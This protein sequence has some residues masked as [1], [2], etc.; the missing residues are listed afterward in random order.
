M[1]CDDIPMATDGSES[2]RQYQCEV[3]L[4][5]EAM[6]SHRNV[7]YLSPGKPAQGWNSRNDPGK[8]KK[9]T[10]T[11]RSMLIRRGTKWLHVEY[12]A[13][14]QDPRFSDTV[15]PFEA[16]V[17][18][19]GD[20]QIFQAYSFILLACLLFYS[21]S[22]VFSFRHQLSM[23]FS[24]LRQALADRAQSRAKMREAAA[25]DA[26]VVAKLSAVDVVAKQN[27]V[28]LRQADRYLRSYEVN[29]R[30]SVA[31]ISELLVENAVE[32]LS[33]VVTI[34]I[35]SIM[36]SS[37]NDSSLVEYVGG[38][39]FIQ[40]LGAFNIVLMTITF[41]IK[42]IWFHPFRQ[43]VLTV[44][45]AKSDL[46]N[47]M[48]TM[49]LFMITFAI[50]G[51]IIFGVYDD[52]FDASG[53]GYDLL[54]VT[55]SVFTHLIDPW[56]KADVLTNRF[57]ST[58]YY[59][60]S[61]TFF[62]LI[63]SQF[64]IAVLCDSFTSVREELSAAA[65]HITLKRGW[66]MGN[67][68]W[69]SW[70]TPFQHVQASILPNWAPHGIPLSDLV[71]LLDDADEMTFNQLELTIRT[72]LMNQG[73]TYNLH[74]RQ[75]LRRP[76]S[77]D[78]AG[79][80]K[81]RAECAVQSTQ[82]SQWLF[83]HFAAVPVA[84]RKDPPAFFKFFH[85]NRVL[86]EMD[87]F[88]LANGFFRDHPAVTLAQS[89]EKEHFRKAFAEY[90]AALQSKP[91]NTVSTFSDEDCGGSELVKVF[92]SDGE[93]TITFKDQT[94]SARLVLG[95]DQSVASAIITKL[96]LHLR[97]QQVDPT[98]D[99]NVVLT[100]D[101]TIVTITNPKYL[102]PNIHVLSTL[103]RKDEARGPESVMFR[104]TIME[105]SHEEQ[106]DGHMEPLNKHCHFTR[107][108]GGGA[109][110][111]AS[112]DAV[113]DEFSEAY[114]IKWCDETGKH[115]TLSEHWERNPA[116]AEV[117]CNY[118]DCQGA[119]SLEEKV[120]AALV[121]MDRTVGCTA[122]ERANAPSFR[123]E[124]LEA[125]KDDEGCPARQEVGRT[126]NASE[127]VVRCF[128]FTKNERHDELEP[129][130]Q[131]CFQNPSTT[132]RSFSEQQLQVFRKQFKKFDK[133]KGADG[134]LNFV[135]LTAVLGSLGMELINEDT[136]K[137]VMK[138]VDQ[139]HSK[140]LEFSEFI[141][142]M[143]QLAI[144]CHFETGESMDLFSYDGFGY[145]S[146][147]MVREWLDAAAELTGEEEEA[148]RYLASSSL[149]SGSGT[150]ASGHA[151]AGS[152]DDLKQVKNSVRR[153]EEQVE[154]LTNKFDRLLQE[155][156]QPR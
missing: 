125:V 104:K 3:L 131:L 39:S 27:H 75:A 54:Y 137:Q 50:V 22:L 74:G 106:F 11:M 28:L 146:F 99:G 55:V 98:L 7:V 46:L 130:Y 6:G 29:V 120:T 14:I 60:A 144:L 122:M 65:S 31:K 90:M 13:K 49:I 87:R 8:G 135:E 132:G 107:V 72:F 23:S 114:E 77:D 4:D 1:T 103:G 26:A 5:R 149:A 36:I 45:H 152:G 118:F 153:V 42:M 129:E 76:V 44:S 156:Q 53:S 91:V 62:L 124:F 57:A 35:T 48:V 88:K 47:F 59:V 123:I 78:A 79:V 66:Q 2:G 16:F 134:E 102:E 70:M 96:P 63:F 41:C 147:G 86:A 9:I 117:L 38:I 148:K 43:L 24:Y 81:F 12:A 73:R 69:A 17:G 142:L 126:L 18:M 138:E 21:W 133:Q 33:W 71:D 105:G 84:L 109:S 67:A 145:M 37:S 97:V 30:K 155:L 101:N 89:K 40:Q 150:G 85:T 56:E 94:Q 116:T 95:N 51:V 64:L 115:T 113:T 20:S 110:V 127:A 80:V 121:E 34:V 100:D 32:L 82:I 15:T 19:E 25:L 58:L 136:L 141:K 139:D 112:Q 68:D 10:W 111:R 92:Q 83:V 93:F 154:L 151:H 140:T 61:T 119:A 128:L 52:A 108:D 143:K